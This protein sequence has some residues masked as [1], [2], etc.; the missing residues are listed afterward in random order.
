L[1]PLDNPIW[2]SLTGLHATF[3]HGGDNLKMYPIEMAPF[4]AVPQMS[5]LPAKLLDVTM[6]E[7]E[8]VY[9]V[10][11]LPQIDGAGFKIEPHPDILQMVCTELRS[12]PKKAGATV[13]P[14][15][16]SH[17]PAM[18]D[19]MARVYPAYFRA[20]TIEMGAYAGVFDGDKLVAMAGL[21]MAP[22][23]FREISGVCTDPRY[24]GRGYAGAL[25]TH[26]AKGVFA[27]G[28]IPMLHQDLD[29]SRARRGLRTAGIPRAHGAADARDPP[30]SLKVRLLTCLEGG[31]SGMLRRSPGR[32]RSLW[33][34]HALYPSETILT[35]RSSFRASHQRT[36]GGNRRQVRP[37]IE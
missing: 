27:D 5:L 21:R 24:T 20:R 28:M 22:Q 9:F 8:F 35:L 18:L 25:I 16:S 33:Q 26:L 31:P 36:K 2:S 6:G 13:Q 29:N 37:W 11:A 3:A 7:R 4:A 30:G 10:G 12:A 23:G 19:L 1:Q 34:A 14:L 32:S 15:D 17:V